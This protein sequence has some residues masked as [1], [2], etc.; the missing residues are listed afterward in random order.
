MKQQLKG[1]VTNTN[2]QL[3]KCAISL[4]VTYQ[5]SPSRNAGPLAC[6][7]HTARLPTPFEPQRSVQSRL[8][9]CHLGSRPWENAFE[10]YLTRIEKGLGLERGNFEIVEGRDSFEIVEGN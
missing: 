5:V 4:A 9:N 7:S 10:K 3:P 8:G 1:Y 2:L 6:S